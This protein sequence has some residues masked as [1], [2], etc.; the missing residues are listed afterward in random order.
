MYA[1]STSSIT[2]Y[3]YSILIEVGRSDRTLGV[4]VMKFLG[5]R[6]QLEGLIRVWRLAH[7]FGIDSLE[8]KAVNAFHEAIDAWY[9]LYGLHLRD[10]TLASFPT[11]RITALIDAMYELYRDNRI[12]AHPTFRSPLLATA[13]CGIHKL[14]ANADMASL[15]DSSPSFAADWAR[16]LMHRWTEHAESSDQDVGFFGDSSPS[17][18][19]TSPG[20]ARCYEQFDEEDPYALFP[21]LLRWAKKDYY[22]ELCSSCLPK[23]TL[24]EWM[25]A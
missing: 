20:C 13:L 25:K 1:S 11:A 24:E 3:I 4:S 12:D 23:I 17:A 9:K 2:P 16:V 19:G 14:R 10:E 6:S 18:T 7:Y 22:E 15:L 21:N 5:K 8:S